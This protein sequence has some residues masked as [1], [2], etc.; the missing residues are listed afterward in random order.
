MTGMI[1]SFNMTREWAELG[2]GERCGCG[3]G[4]NPY[5]K[6]NSMAF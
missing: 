3:S 1:I 2:Y 6:G 5:P 4:Q